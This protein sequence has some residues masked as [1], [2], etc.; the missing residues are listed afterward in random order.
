MLKELFGPVSLRYDCFKW[1]ACYTNS[2]IVVYGVIQLPRTHQNGENLTPP[3]TY[4]HVR[5]LLTPSCIRTF[6][7]LT[8]ISNGKCLNIQSII[9]KRKKLFRHSRMRFQVSLFLKPVFKCIRFQKAPVSN[10]SGSYWCG[11]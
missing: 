9:P 10:V 1:H 7:H 4:T 5:L 11:R 2:Q 6:T 3:P 8:P